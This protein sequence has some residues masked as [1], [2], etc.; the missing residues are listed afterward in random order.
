MPDGPGT[1]AANRGLFAEVVFVLAAVGA[2]AFELQNS[3]LTVQSRMWPLII[4]GFM[5]LT[6]VLL[7]VSALLAGP[8]DSSQETAE[9]P[10]SQA[11][12]DR[13]LNR[14]K[15]M[16]AYAA[17]VLLLPHLGFALTTMIF[18]PVASLLLDMPLRLKYIALS[19]A[20]ALG[21]HMLF[22]EAFSVPL[23]EGPLER[24]L[25]PF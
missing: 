5:A 22:S 20:V 4:L 19:L 14:Y 11:G 16:V 3:G 23:P 25:L 9:E 12:R 24:V 13:P 7:L 10:S 21:I 6:A 15:M 17:L 1:L 8:P 18:V 2:L